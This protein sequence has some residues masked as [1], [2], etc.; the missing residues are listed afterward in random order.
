MTVYV[1]ASQM[2]GYRDIRLIW[3]L[4]ASI[5]GVVPGRTT[6]LV[7]QTG[8]DG[9]AIVHTAARDDAASNEC[10]LATPG[11]SG[12]FLWAIAQYGVRTKKRPAMANKQWVWMWDKQR[13]KTGQRCLPGSGC[14]L[15]RQTE[16]LQQQATRCDTAVAGLWAAKTKG[17]FRC[18]E[19]RNNATQQ[20]MPRGACTYMSP[21]LAVPTSGR[22]RAG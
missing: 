18:Q 15:G 2:A 1:F 13:H 5:F 11:P 7:R 3:K 21:T 19:T 9:D 6:R 12:P 10:A 8:L 4:R 14:T 20:W 16:G 17:A 22:E